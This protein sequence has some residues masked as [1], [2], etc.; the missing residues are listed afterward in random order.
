VSIAN[1][2][3]GRRVRTRVRSIDGNGDINITLE[4]NPD[5]CYCGY[6]ASD[7]NCDSV[8]AMEQ[9]TTLL[10]SMQS[11]TADDRVLE[12]SFLTHGELPIKRQRISGINFPTVYT[13]IEGFLP[14]GIL[15]A[16][17]RELA[18]GK[19]SH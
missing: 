15:D 4:R 2:L 12:F 8:I 16:D 5:R 14:E 11:L 18:F 3:I 7:A 10:Q 17:L 19:G 13:A 6:F 9:N 1:Y